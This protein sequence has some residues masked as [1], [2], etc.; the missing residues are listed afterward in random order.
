MIV[1]PLLTQRDSR[2][3]NKTL[4]F[5]NLKI[6]PYGCTLTCLTA[7]LSVV[8]GRPYRVDE[9]NDA[10]KKVNGFSGA[11]LLWSNVPK[12]FPKLRWIKRGYNYNNMEVAFNIYVRNIPVMVEVNGAKIG[13]SKHWVLF[14]GD[15]KAL[16]PWTG[17]LIATNYYPLTGYG[18]YN[19]T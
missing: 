8:Y 18:L 11:L 13:A 19:R 9:V 16:D 3:A 4:G 5:S 7:L 15:G 1:A 10:L 2:W 17:R 12:A 14:L 6:G